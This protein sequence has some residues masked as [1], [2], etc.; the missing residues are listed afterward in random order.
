MAT[1][2]KD[3]VVHRAVGNNDNDINNNDDDDDKKKK[4]K[5]DDDGGGDDDD[6]N[7]NDDDDDDDDDNNNNNNSLK[8]MLKI[9]ITITITLKLKGAIRDLLTASRTV[10]NTYAQGATAQLCANHV[11]HMGRLSPCNISCAT[12]YERTA[13][14]LNLIDEIV[15]ILT[16]S[17]WL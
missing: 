6:S 4:K 9:M 13:H 2:V 15:Y 8:M 5:N 7:K 1:E 17:N 11:Q 10:L 16:L 14:L 3:C 12:W